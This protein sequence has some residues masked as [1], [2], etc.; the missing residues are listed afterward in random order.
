VHPVQGKDY[1]V[2]EKTLSTLR[3]RGRGYLIQDTKYRVLHVRRRPRK[4]IV[5][6][7]MKWKNSPSGCRIW[8][9]QETD[10]VR[11]SHFRCN[12]LPAGDY[13]ASWLPIPR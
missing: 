5:G 9:F 2:K 6:Y 11:E 13:K 3:R 1:E 10:P 8:H 12:S 7:E 4:N